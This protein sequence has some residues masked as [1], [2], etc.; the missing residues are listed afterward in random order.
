MISV[1]ISNPLGFTLMQI[2][3]EVAALP[4]NKRTDGF[5]HFVGYSKMEKKKIFSVLFFYVSSFF[6]YLFFRDNIRN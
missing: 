6:Q 5:D 1:V 3:S 2:S 4:M